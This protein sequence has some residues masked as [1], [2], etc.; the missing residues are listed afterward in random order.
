MKKPL[1]LVIIV[2]N[3]AEYF[4]EWAAHYRTLNVKNLFVYDNASTDGTTELLA[5]LHASGIV[6]V[7]PWIVAE[8][9]SP[10][11]SCYADATQQLR[12]QYEFLAFFDTDEFLVVQQQVELEPWLM[13]LPGDVSA[14][15]VNQRVFGSSGHKTK[16]PGLVVDRFRRASSAGYDENLWVKSIYRSSAIAEIRSPHRGQIM[17][18]RYIL[19]NGEDAFGSEKDSGK[20]VAIDFSRLQ[21]NHY[22]IKSEEEFIAK[23]AR[24]GVMAAT[25]EQRLKRYEDL[26]FFHGRDARINDCVEEMLAKRIPLIAAEIANLQKCLEKS[27]QLAELVQDRAT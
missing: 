1:G 9:I 20:A 25:V 19:P 22:I 4:L 11:M 3:E 12:D 10:Q 15:A 24:G 18:G 27:K 2:K 6:T 23:R 13:S 8:G 14:I 17:S 16:T 7:K 26:N 5:Q 21:L